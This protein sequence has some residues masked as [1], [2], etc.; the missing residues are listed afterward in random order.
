MN[1][2]TYFELLPIDIYRTVMCYARTRNSKLMGE[3]YEKTTLIR[4][5]IEKSQRDNLT[6][7]FIRRGLDGIWRMEMNKFSMPPKDDIYFKD[8]TK[9]KLRYFYYPYGYNMIYYDNPH[10][11]FIIR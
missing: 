4:L 5:D 8:Y 1:D 9:L 11:E 6:K 3:L 10:L 7:R 2:R